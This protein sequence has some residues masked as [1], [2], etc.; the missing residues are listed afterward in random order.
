MWCPLSEHE[1]AVEE[2]MKRGILGIPSR[3]QAAA[4]TWAQKRVV[5]GVEN[6]VGGPSA[7]SCG[8]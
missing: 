2:S 7:T 3:L 5:T 1:E 6:A 4:K 8:R